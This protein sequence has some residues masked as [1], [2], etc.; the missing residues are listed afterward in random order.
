M[1]NR[2]ADQWFDRAMP[3]E[4]L[5]GALLGAVGQGS[6]DGRV[7]QALE[8]A[9]LKYLPTPTGDFMVPF[10][11]PNGRKHSVCVESQTSQL[12]SLEIR[13]VWSVSYFG[14]E[15]PSAQVLER[16]LS[17]GGRLKM[18][19]F[20]LHAQAQ[21]AEPRHYAVVFRAKVPVDLSP[22]HLH[23]VTCAVAATADEM[24]ASL[25]GRDEF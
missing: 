18:G 2:S 7:R 8:K 17:A 5:L 4:A 6:A 9:G 23:A 14:T 22:E 13:D 3:V 16:L 21:D 10:R 15:P 12:G 1:R 20:E 19:A 25:T 11:L 24:E